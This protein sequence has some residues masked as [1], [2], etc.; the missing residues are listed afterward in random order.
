MDTVKKLVD[1]DNIKIADVNTVHII[2][3]IEGSKN[4]KKRHG[5]S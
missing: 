5:R 1:K 4:D 3:N 2:R